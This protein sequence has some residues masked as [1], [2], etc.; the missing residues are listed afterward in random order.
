MAFSLGHIY[1]ADT[2]VH[3]VHRW[4]LLWF[5]KQVSALVERNLCSLTRP[6]WMELSSK[7]IFPK[8]A[9]PNPIPLLPVSL[10]HA[11]TAD[12]GGTHLGEDLVKPLQGPIQV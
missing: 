6:S 4:D 9:L 2:A 5:Q 11:G 3:K 12:A 1:A 7:V 8:P 10:R